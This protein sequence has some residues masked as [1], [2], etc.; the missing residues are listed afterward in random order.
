[1]LSEKECV[2]ERLREP[3]VPGELDDADLRAWYGPEVGREVIERTFSAGIIRSVERV[4]SVVI[5]RSD[6][7]QCRASPRTAPRGRREVE[8]RRVMDNGS[9]RRPFLL[10]TPSGGIPELSRSD[11][12]LWL[13]VALRSGPVG[14]A[15]M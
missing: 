4:V 15:E 9:N 11:R 8:D 10:P 12:G 14:L 1:M 3:R 6:F 7:V 2:G 13:T 5:I